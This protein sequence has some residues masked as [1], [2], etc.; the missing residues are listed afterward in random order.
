[1]LATRHLLRFG[2]AIFYT[3]GMISAVESYQVNG[4]FSRVFL[5]GCFP[6]GP[7]FSE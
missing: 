7:H 4:V 1:L 5:I 2:L 6:S 3:F